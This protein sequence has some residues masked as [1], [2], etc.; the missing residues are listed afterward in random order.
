MSLPEIHL[1]GATTFVGQAF[2]N[3]CRSNSDFSE[4]YCYSRAT[5]ELGNC[6]TFVD[7]D[8]PS[9]FT[10]AG[11][12]NHPM[13][14]ISFAP[15]WKFAP[16]LSQLATK[17][18]ERLHGLSGLI[19]CSS[20]SVITKRFAVNQ[21]DK[22]LASSL[23]NAEISVVASCRRLKIPCHILQ[24]SVIYGRIGNY[25]DRNLS[26]LLKLLRLFPFI[27]LPSKSGLRQPIHAQQLASV[28]LSLA[29]QLF[30]SGSYA[31][32]HNTIA[33]GGDTTLSYYE[34]IRALQ[35]SQST[36]DPALHCFIFQVPNRL[37]YLFCSPLLLVAPK[38]FEALYR[39]GS[40]L[41]GFT[42][43]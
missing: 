43:A 40:D 4:I 2:I 15:I 3:S 10:R 29:H 9:N 32:S 8:N 34:M 12:D 41:A 18:P 35:N 6:L 31:F 11:K 42:P 24:P 23:V 25:C 21:F 28:V 37:F 26:V 38:L 19:L 27:I 13:I 33:L 16:F 30:I 17:F 20:S 39:I 5:S 14:W 22:K 1:F 36:G 7:L